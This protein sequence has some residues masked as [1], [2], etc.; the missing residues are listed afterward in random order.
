MGTAATDLVLTVP[1]WRRW[2]LLGALLALGGLY[3]A[4]YAVFVL[5]SRNFID[6]Q[7]NQRAQRFAQAHV[8]TLPA[9]LN[10]GEDQPGAG[11]LGGGWYNPERTGVWSASPDA[12]IHLHVAGAD[13]EL[14]LQLS[15]NA[16]VVRHHSRIRIS[17]D[18]DA[19]MLGS[20][21]RRPA[22]ATEPLRL[23]IPRS[24]ARSGKWVIHVH[25]DKP[26]SPRQVGPSDDFR[27]LGWFLTS[28]DL[29]AIDVP[30]ADTIDAAH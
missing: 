9:R 17:V 24:L 18:I 21:E 5:E 28:L 30:K 11:N 20:W 29:T 26:V 2:L 14:E 1:A 19:T 25:I 23:R 27:Q 15:G 13:S 12:W 4:A 3:V 8:L 16:F 22:N 7:R 6:V 10:F